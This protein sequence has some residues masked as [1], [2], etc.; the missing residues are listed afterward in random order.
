MYF[1]EKKKKMDRI[2]IHTH[3]GLRWVAL[4]LL[5]ASIVNAIKMSKSNSFE[6]KDRM[7]YM[8]TMVSLHIQLVIG[9][10][11]Y[12]ISN[13]VQF[14]DK[15]MSSDTANGMFRFYNMEHLLMMVAAIT[16]VTMGHV[17]A[18][19]ATDNN[20]KHA[21]IRLW[22][23]IGLAL[24]IIGIPWPFREYLGGAWF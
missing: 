6:K 18:K 5:I 14:V 15:W 4:I 9:L 11:L 23:I 24:I 17:L 12:F 1:C 16:L 21:I 13:K 10:V 22:Y 19:R 7:L 2:L 20:R 8:F 3:S